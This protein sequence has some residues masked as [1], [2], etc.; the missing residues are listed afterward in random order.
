[1]PPAVG[2]APGDAG[3]VGADPVGADPVDASYFRPAP[4]GGPTPVRQQTQGRGQAHPQDQARSWEQA[5][6]RNPAHPR[7]RARSWEQARSQEPT[8]NPS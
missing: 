4:P 2:A 5:H 1:V 3:L 8:K 7:Q 6:S